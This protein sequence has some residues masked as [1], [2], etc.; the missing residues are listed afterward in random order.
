MPQFEHDRSKYLSQKEIDAMRLALRGQVVLKVVAMLEALGVDEPAI[1]T[2][3]QETR[4]NIAGMP[5]DT[6]RTLGRQAVG[7]AQLLDGEPLDAI[8]SEEGDPFVVQQQPVEQ[9]SVIEPTE[10]ISPVDTEQDVASEV[11][12]R[13]RVMRMKP[14][15]ETVRYDTA[16][17]T[18]TEIARIN[19]ETV[20]A[21]IAYMFA[22]IFSFD[23]LK[24]IEKS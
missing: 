7:I 24:L 2:A 3:V 10:P 6:L 15:G 16:V 14:N 9:I 20:S 4:K 8:E 13:K 21:D 5:L 19:E 12:K 17:R 22:K 18:P 11:P 23:E 1:E